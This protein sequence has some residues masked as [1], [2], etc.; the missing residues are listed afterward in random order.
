MKPPAN[1]IITNHHI[2]SPSPPSYSSS[3]FSLLWCMFG[4]TSVLTVFGPTFIISLYYHW[5]DIPVSF[6]CKCIG[7]L[8]NIS[9][10]KKKSWIIII[11]IIIQC[12]EQISAYKLKRRNDDSLNYLKNALNLISGFVWVETLA[13]HILYCTVVTWMCASYSATQFTVL[14]CWCFV[15]KCWT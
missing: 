11:I 15:C 5:P 3:S 2:S 9:E 12:I 4:G 13:V 8:V 10:D 1:I 14:L 7:A 6:V